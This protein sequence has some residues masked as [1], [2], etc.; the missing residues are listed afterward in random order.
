MKSDDSHQSTSDCLERV[1]QYHEQT[2]HDFN[3]YARSLG[4]MDWANQPDPFRRFEGAP[5][6]PLPRLTLEDISSVFANFQ[7]YLYQPQVVL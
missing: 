2:K 5:L 7:K 1:K 6:I 4:Y 3:Q